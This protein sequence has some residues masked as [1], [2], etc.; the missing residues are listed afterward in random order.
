MKKMGSGYYLEF[1]MK[2]IFK[3]GIYQANSDIPA[4]IWKRS[5]FQKIEK[6][7]P[8]TNSDSNMIL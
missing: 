6:L 3:L 7:F 4:E 1:G 5:L 8:L 2:N